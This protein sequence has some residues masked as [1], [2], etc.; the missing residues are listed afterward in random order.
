MFIRSDVFKGWHVQIFILDQSWYLLTWQ[1]SRY[2]PMWHPESRD[3]TWHII[4]MLAWH[5]RVYSADMDMWCAYDV[6]LIIWRVI[7]VAIESIQWWDSYTWQCMLC[8]TSLSLLGW[9]MWTDRTNRS[10]RWSSQCSLVS[11]HADGSG[12]SESYGLIC[13]SHWALTCADGSDLTRSGLTSHKILGVRFG[14]FLLLALTGPDRL[15]QYA[16]VMRASDVLVT[17]QPNIF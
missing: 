2:R 5:P 1:K 14:F 4:M 15:A 10:I 3:A 11:T 9:P 8:W 7:D 6:A 17:H 16:S 12:Q 13:L